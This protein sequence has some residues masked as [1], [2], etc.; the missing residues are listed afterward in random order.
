LKRGTSRSVESIAPGALLLAALAGVCGCATPTRDLFDDPAD[1]SRP[2]FSMLKDLSGIDATP[3][4]DL[5]GAGGAGDLGGDLKGALDL[6]TGDL[7]AV[8]NAADTCANAPFLAAGVTYS[9]HDTTNLV[10]DYDFGNAPSAACLAAFNGFGY[11]GHDGAYRFSIDPGKTLTV[12]M[13]KSNLPT[14]WDPALAIVTSC[15]S[16]GPSCL[17][18]SDEVLGNTET[19]SYQNGSAS[20]LQVYILVDSYLPSEFGKY[21]IRADLQ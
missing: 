12:V 5:G 21:A 20:P 17:S 9:G 18:G 10:D 2:P 16:A 14:N 7:G 3:G 1:L 19:V 15:A 6:A 11:D 13:T 4:P 8:V